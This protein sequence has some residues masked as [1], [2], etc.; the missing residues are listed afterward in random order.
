MV[1]IFG[2]YFAGLSWNNDN[3]NVTLF[4]WH[5]L[6]YL[7]IN[8]TSLGNTFMYRVICCGVY[9]I[10]AILPFVD[11]FSTLLK[12]RNNTFDKDDAL[13]WRFH[14]QDN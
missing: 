13:V 6:L 8:D 14:I 4:V 1:C 3:C 12:S 10:K 9:S 7:C 2:L 11:E 5:I